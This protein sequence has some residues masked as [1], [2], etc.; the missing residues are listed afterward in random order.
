MG[1]SRHHSSIFWLAI[2]CLTWVGLAFGYDQ[3]DFSASGRKWQ[4]APKGHR[5]GQDNGP[6]VGTHNAGEDCGICHRPNGKAGKYVFSMAGTLYEDRASRRPANDGEIILQDIQGKVISMTTNGAGNFWT[7]ATIGSN[8]WSLASHGGKTVTLYSGSDG[9]LAPAPSHDSRTW[10]YKTWV[11]TGDQVRPMVTIAP[12][13]MSTDSTSRMSCNM[14]HAPMGARGG[15]WSARKSTLSSCPS[16]AVRF[17]KHILAILKNK[18]VPCHTPGETWTRVVTRSDHEGTTK[19]D[20]SGGLDL[21]T[22]GGSKVTVNRVVWEKRGA[23]SVAIPGDPGNSLLLLKTREGGM[24]HAGGW[25]WGA[26]DGDYKAIRQW[27][28]EEAGDN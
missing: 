9:K 3:T 25:F 11:R 17:Q 1:K 7:Y 20:Y 12:V 15:L 6:G 18:C 23:R 21:T 27:I 13:G 26:E 22:Y 10:Q 19:M 4:P 5:P 2:I 16:S 28:K 8:P 14:H 24:V